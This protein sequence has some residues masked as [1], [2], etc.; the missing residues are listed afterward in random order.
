MY[1]PKKNQKSSKT[2]TPPKS[3]VSFSR[4]TLSIFL[5]PYLYLP[6]MAL[7]SL[8]DVGKILLLIPLISYIVDIIRRRD[9]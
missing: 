2:V 7:F 3:Q 1:P 4:N 5:I 9:L 8:Q 6:A